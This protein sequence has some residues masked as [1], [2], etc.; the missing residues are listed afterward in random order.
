VLA[1]HAAVNTFDNWFHLL[2]EHPRQITEPDRLLPLAVE[3]R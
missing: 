1:C 3:K 2:L